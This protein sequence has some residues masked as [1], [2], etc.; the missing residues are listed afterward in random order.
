VQFGNQKEAN[1]HPEVALDNSCSIIEYFA[2]YL[3]LISLQE[4]P[5]VFLDGCGCSLLGQHGPLS[6]ESLVNLLFSQG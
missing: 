4:H 1:V 6:H 5:Y 3:K 2:E